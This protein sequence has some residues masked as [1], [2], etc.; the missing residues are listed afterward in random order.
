LAGT[1]QSPT[2][3]GYNPQN[4][5]INW[6][7]DVPAFS[8]KPTG[9][10]TTPPASPPVA[11]YSFDPMAGSPPTAG[12]NYGTG[13][14]TYMGQPISNQSQLGQA[15][16]GFYGALGWPMP[17][18]AP[19]PAMNVPQDWRMGT[20]AQPNPNFGAPAPRTALEPQ[21]YDYSPNQPAWV[22]GN[23]PNAGTNKMPTYTGPTYQAGTP[24]PAPGS[25]SGTPWQYNP[26]PTDKFGF[27]VL[28]PESAPSPASGPGTIPNT[29]GG[30]PTVAEEPRQRI[31]PSGQSISRTRPPRRLGATT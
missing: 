3:G 27:A 10:F 20:P 17:T 6:N 18:Q 29:T 5:S 7:P 21:Q 14:V 16:Q 23:G 22:W 13:Q 26:L 2:Y 31:K 28:P 12:V 1:T 15:Q 19:A 25:G 30:I 11:N 8:A 4:P 9:A 24:P